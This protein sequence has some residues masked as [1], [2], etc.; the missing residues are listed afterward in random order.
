M[1]GEKGR[2]HRDGGYKNAGADRQN[3]ARQKHSQRD[4]SVYH[5]VI[6]MP[7]DIP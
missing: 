5:N 6:L 1:P 3:T 7:K 4:V 2:R